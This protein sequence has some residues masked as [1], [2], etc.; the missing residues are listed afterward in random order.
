MSNGGFGGIHAKLLARFG[1]RASAAVN[2]QRDITVILKSR[3]PVVVV[4]TARRGARPRAAGA[5]RQSRK[6][7]ALCVER[8]RPLAPRRAYRPC[9][10]DERFADCLHCPLRRDGMTVLYLH[11]FNSAPQSRKAYCAVHDS[12]GLGDRFVCPKLPHRPAAAIALAERELERATKPDPGRQLARWLL[13]D[14]YRGN[15]G[16]PAVLINPAVRR[17]LIWKA[18]LA[19][20]EPVYGRRVMC[21]P[22]NISTN[23]ATLEATVAH[24]ER[25]SAPRRDGRR[26][27]D[28]RASSPEIRR[29]ASRS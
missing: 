28:Y 21:L 19:S 22:V 20:N 10:A 15:I 24:P 29:R 25:L 7:G 3:F 23:G 9:R 16:S 12:R 11:G 5:R 8:G 17:R 4:E 13:C 18:T 14:P 6:L 26:S 27:A 2:D 1:D